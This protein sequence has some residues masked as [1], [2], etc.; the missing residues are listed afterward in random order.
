MVLA[1]ISNPRE[2]HGKTDAIH[3]SREADVS[4]TQR[5][6][7]WYSSEDSLSAEPTINPTIVTASTLTS[8]VRSSR[9]PHSTMTILVRSSP[10]LNPGHI[11]TTPIVQPTLK[12]PT[13]PP[14][15]NI[16]A[17]IRATG[18]KNS[19]LGSMTMAM[20]NIRYWLSSICWSTLLRP[21][22]ELWFSVHFCSQNIRSRNW[23][24]Q[25]FSHAISV[26]NT[27]VF[28]VEDIVSQVMNWYLTLFQAL[29]IINTMVSLVKDIIYFVMIRFISGGQY[30]LIFICV[31]IHFFE[32]M[33]LIII[34]LILIW[35]SQQFMLVRLSCFL[36]CLSAEFSNVWAVLSLPDPH[37]ILFHYF[38]LS[39]FA[40][41]AILSV[42]FIFAVKLFLYYVSQSPKRIHT[43]NVYMYILIHTQNVYMYILMS[44]PPLTV[45]DI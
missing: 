5:V 31:S 21:P 26:I 3:H 18:P 38:S 4:G 36:A 23:Q 22:Q 40:F 6:R 1:V 10:S 20:A 19:T 28:L 29:S 15:G 44:C 16:P 39:F 45:Y 9:R 41:N 8:L 24:Y 43:Q 35:V 17:A 14:S 32:L 25:S 33:L 42:V 2:N 13:I 34:I 12:T 30:Y 27:M 37:F 11:C 7:T